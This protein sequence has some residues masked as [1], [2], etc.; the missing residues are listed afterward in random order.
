MKFG[1][2]ISNS[3]AYMDMWRAIQAACKAEEL[4]YDSVFFSDHYMTPYSPQWYETYEVLPFLGFLA[5]KTTK[6]RLGTCVTPI[7]FRPPGILAKIISTIDNLSR[8]RVI[9]GIGAGWVQGEFEAYSRWDPPNIRVRKT[10][11]GLDLIIKL[12][13]EEVV[14]FEGEFY[15]AKR[16]VLKPKPYQKP[17]PPIWFGTTGKFMLRMTAKL[18]DGWIPWVR[19]TPEQYGSC[20][21]TIKFHAKKFGR[22]KRIT[23]AS[24]IGQ[25]TVEGLKPILTDV[26][27]VTRWADRVQQY[28]DNGCEYPILW[29]HPKIHIE[30]MER[31]ARDVIPSFE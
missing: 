29:F 22:E 25:I 24:V 5:A 6:I 21:E 20:V 10:L 13:T 15:K 14:D 16:A 3:Y 4:G 27:M 2:M 17:Y 11:E 8:G 9:F 23:F 1:V 12:W 26:P 31:F 19:V 18:G 7:P 30:L 28:I